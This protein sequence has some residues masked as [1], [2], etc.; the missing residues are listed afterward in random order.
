MCLCPNFLNFT[1]YLD[2]VIY[3]HFSSNMLTL[4]SKTK[5]NTIANTPPLTFKAVLNFGN[6]NIGECVCSV[7]VIQP[8]LNVLIYHYLLTYLLHGAESFLRS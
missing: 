2:V 5:G 3:T 1:C 4:K 6:R 7:T 8:L